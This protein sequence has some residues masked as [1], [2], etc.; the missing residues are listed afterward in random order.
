MS[1]YDHSEWLAEQEKEIKRK[2]EKQQERSAKE[3]KNVVLGEI[4]QLK[5][6]QGDLNKVYTKKEIASIKKTE[7]K[8]VK[9]ELIAEQKQELKEAKTGFE[10]NVKYYKSQITQLKNDFN[11]TKKRL[12]KIDKET[13]HFIME[14][15]NEKWEKQWGNSE[16]KTRRK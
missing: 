7:L 9:D 6:N 1:Y 12:S 5:G 16:K 11:K 8:E 3:K 14:G 15:L 13:L 2:L 10:K 4:K